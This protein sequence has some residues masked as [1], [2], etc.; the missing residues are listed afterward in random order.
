MSKK[1]EDALG[2]KKLSTS[3]PENEQKWIGTQYEEIQDLVVIK[4]KWHS[5]GG[6]PKDYKC[7]NCL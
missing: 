6:R 5:R 7:K 4:I 3:K 1:Y 2:F